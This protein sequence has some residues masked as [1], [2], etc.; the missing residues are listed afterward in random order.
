V[1][2]EALDR[3]RRHLKQ[4]SHLTNGQQLLHYSVS[5]VYVPRDQSNFAPLGL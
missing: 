2:F 3:T 4:V 1:N 5:F